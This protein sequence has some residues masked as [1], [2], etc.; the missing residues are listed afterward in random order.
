MAFRKAGWL[1]VGS[2]VVGYVRQLLEPLER[3]SANLVSAKRGVVTQALTNLVSVS[4]AGSWTL[5]GRDFSSTA[6]SF[7]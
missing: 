6:Q 3:E 5:R 2:L 1:V 4:I 7:S